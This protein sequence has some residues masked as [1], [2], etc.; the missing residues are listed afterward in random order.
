MVH[1][2][3]IFEWQ[4][5]GLSFSIVSAKKHRSQ[6]VPKRPALFCIS[7][8]TINACAVAFPC[9]S[10]HKRTFLPSHDNRDILL[11]LRGQATD[12][13]CAAGGDGVFDSGRSA[14]V[15]G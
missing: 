10:Q 14:I 5:A 2:I 12:P 3:P 13:V 15:G 4:P 11:C 6:S 7:L 1:V 9:V 8:L